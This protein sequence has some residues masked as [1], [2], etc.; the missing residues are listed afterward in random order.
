MGNKMENRKQ[1]K[2]MDKDEMKRYILSLGR[3]EL[4]DEID[5]MRSEV[6]KRIPYPRYLKAIR[7]S[8]V[9]LGYDQQW[10]EGEFRDALDKMYLECSRRED[11]IYLYN[12]KT[13]KKY[14][15]YTEG[16]SILREKTK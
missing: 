11:G 9:A 12:S 1:G 6:G 15:A 7:V 13:T 2:T 4:F 14:D 16:L 5:H 8:L 3:S 10:V